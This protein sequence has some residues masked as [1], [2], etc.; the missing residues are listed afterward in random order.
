MVSTPTTYGPVYDEEREILIRAVH[1][2]ANYHGH[3]LIT[4]PAKF[5]RDVLASFIDL[6]ARSTQPLPKRM[7]NTPA[8]YG[9]AIHWQDESGGWHTGRIVLRPSGQNA[10]EYTPSV[11]YVSLVKEDCCGTLTWV[12]ESALKPWPSRLERGEE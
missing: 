8:A 10:T 3:H 9:T 6:E 11:G 4:E 7:T 12:A 1:I 5:T 2:L